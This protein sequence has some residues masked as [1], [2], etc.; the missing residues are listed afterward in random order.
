MRLSVPWRGTWR[1]TWLSVVGCASIASQAVACGRP[2]AEIAGQPRG[3]ALDRDDP[4]TCEGCHPA[5]YQGWA[6]SMHAYASEDPIFRA[7]NARGQRDTGGALGDFC[8][9][10]HAPLAVARGATTDGRNLADLPAAL[11][12]VTCVVCHSAAGAGGASTGL[13]NDDV[14]RGPIADPVTTLA[15]RSVYSPAHDRDRPEAA[16]LCGTCHA[17]TNGHGLEVE[18]TIDEWRTTRYAQPASLR[19]C[20]RC[21]MP[22]TPGLAADV[23]GAPVRAVH[24]HAM[25]GVDLGAASQMQRKLVQE[26]IDP[27]LSSKLCVVPNASGAQVSVTLTNALVGH[28]WPSGATNNR[29]GWAEVVAYAGGAIAYASGVVGANE[30]VTASSSP[31]LLV[32]G[33]QLFDDR[34]APTPFM[35]NAQSAR[36]SLLLPAAADPL[37]AAQSAAVQI[38]ATGVDRVTARV[39]LRAFDQDVADALVASGDL[40]RVVASQ[41]PTLTVGATVLEW[42]A[43]R[44]AACLP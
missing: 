8:V 5:H 33:E 32:F 36:S 20:G 29:R 13:G 11:G 19:T 39:Q 43:D 42:T 38:A 27:S 4:L 2:G 41:L 35:W 30:S 31:P 44:G 21:H 37:Q 22:E 3:E 25:P 6:L 24:G 15:H 12:G 16:T 10:C 17:V 23:L 1:G 40:S 14:M 26:M 7:M 34:G 28:A 9:R 18:R